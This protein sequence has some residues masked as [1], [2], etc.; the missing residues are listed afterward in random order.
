LVDGHEPPADVLWRKHV[1]LLVYLALSPDRT[2][3]REHL[4][5]LLWPEKTQE[6]AR[7]SL[8]EAVRRLRGGLGTDRIV[9]NGDVV[10]L[11]D[12][13]LGVDALEFEQHAV[14]DPQGDF[15]EGFGG[16][17]R[18]RGVG[19]GAAAALPVE[20]DVAARRGGRV[21]PCRQP[22]RRCAGR[23]APCADPSAVRRGSG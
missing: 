22:I 4:L 8:N 7:H 13:N 2:R 11:N 14:S 9:T 16:R 10:Q 6:K 20:G 17:A 5:G 23:S 21:S 18:V 15:L 19:G 3:S 1:A 12:Q